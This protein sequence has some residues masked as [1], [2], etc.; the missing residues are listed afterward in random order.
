MKKILTPLALAIGLAI[1]PAANAADFIAKEADPALEAVAELTEQP[2][3][4]QEITE[5]VYVSAEDQLRDLM[6]TRGWGQ[7]WDANKKR[8]FVV[9]SESFDNEDPTYDDSFIAKRSMFS[10]LAVMGA[11]AKVVEFMRTQM[12]A[13]DQLSAPGTNV[14]AELNEQFLKIQKK[15]ASSEKALAKL[16]AEVDAAEAEKLKGVTLEDRTKA[17]MDALIKRLDTAYS[18]GDI[19]EKKRKAYQKAKTRYEEAMAEHEDIVA[20]AE[21]IKGSVALEATSAV[22]TLAKAPLMGTSILAQAES[23]NAEEERYEVAVL[24]VWSPKLEEGAKA[25][26][27]GEE[28]DT[29]PKKALSVQEWLDTQDAATLVGPRSYVDNKGDRWF[30]GAYAMPVSGSSSKIRKN[31]GIA[32]LMAKKEAV[33]ALYSDM[34]TQKQAEIALQT[35][36]GELGGKDHTEVATSFAE[37]TRQAVENRQVNGM[38]QLMSK[39]VTHPISNEKIYVIAYGVSGQSAAEALKLSYSTYQ[40]ATKANLSNS[41]KQVVADKLEQSLE[42]S[43]KA[44]VEASVGT[45]SGVMP[46]KAANTVSHKKV[47]TSSN[48]L[49]NA[50]TIDE[51][52]F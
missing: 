23:W 11:K 49:L 41:V 44:D 15:I 4:Q 17:F 52:D 10:T 20:K 28:Q 13:A 47:A 36:S 8:I 37:T 9:H 22:E 12:T 7:G 16:L 51:D 21:A 26:L 18:S 33:M 34:E 48:T 24:T 30:I 1:L 32:D 25:I 29:K 3:Q 42:A 39:T 27:T 46:T 2:Y 38:S 40:S 14:Y 6:K 45:D 31:K 19:E 35:R 50:P 5:E 43:K